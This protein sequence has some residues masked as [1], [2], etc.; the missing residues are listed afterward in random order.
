LVY[1]GLPDN[2]A[3]RAIWQTTLDKIPNTLGSN[4]STGIDEL[5]RMT[6]G[7]SGAEIVMIAKEAAIECIKKRVNLSED[8]DISDRLASMRLDATEEGLS[9]DISTIKS[10]MSRMRPRTD[11]ALV[12]ALKAFESRIRIE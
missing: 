6:D 1:V 8:E 7:Y 9:L 3:R 12:A 5:V 4:V 2:D 10:V 11:E